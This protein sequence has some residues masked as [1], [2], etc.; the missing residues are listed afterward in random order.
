MQFF[1][2]IKF[3][4]GPICALIFVPVLVITLLVSTTKLYKR[5]NLFFE[6]LVKY[7]SVWIIFFVYSYLSIWIS[8]RKHTG[9]KNI[10]GT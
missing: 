4:I 3:I 1:K 7:I 10:D 8:K 5:N 9:L 6:S 2:L